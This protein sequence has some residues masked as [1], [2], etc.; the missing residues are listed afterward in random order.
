MRGFEQIQ[1][2]V[3]T[4]DDTREGLNR[5]VNATQERQAAIQKK[6]DSAAER[7]LKPIRLLSEELDSMNAQHAQ[8]LETARSYNRIMYGENEA[9]TSIEQSF[10]RLSEKLDSEKK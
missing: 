6:I 4:E 2:A 3:T 5:L 10:R 1:T 7:Y 9:N 8:N